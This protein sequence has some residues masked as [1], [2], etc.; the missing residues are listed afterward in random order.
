MDSKTMLFL[1]IAAL[2]GGVA[3]MGSG[4]DLSVLG[5][6][7]QIAQSPMNATDPAMRRMTRTSM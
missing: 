1:I 7:A 6:M 2:G 3:A 4:I 5:K